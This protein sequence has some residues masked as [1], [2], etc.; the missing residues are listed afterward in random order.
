M[1]YNINK[2]SGQSYK[3][4]YSRNLQLQIHT[5]G[6]FLAITRAITNVLIYI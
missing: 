5:L 3:Q 4:L 6:I 2:H 1:N